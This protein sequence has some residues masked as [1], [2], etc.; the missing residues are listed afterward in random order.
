MFAS[1]GTYQTP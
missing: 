1:L